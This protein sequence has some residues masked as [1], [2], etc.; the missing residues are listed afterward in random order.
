M[1]K[2]FASVGIL[3]ILAGVLTLATA[4]FLHHTTNGLLTTGLLLIVGGS[5]LYVGAIKHGGHY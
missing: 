2:R 5:V 3:L 1:N 4:Y